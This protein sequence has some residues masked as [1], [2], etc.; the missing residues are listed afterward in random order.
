ML[1]NNLLIS[2]NSEENKKIDKQLNEEEE[3]VSSSRRE[4]NVNTAEG[5][6]GKEHRTIIYD[7]RLL[8]DAQKI[9]AIGK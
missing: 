1:K 6:V 5:I 2:W 8:K 4:E 3:I 7:K 9:Q